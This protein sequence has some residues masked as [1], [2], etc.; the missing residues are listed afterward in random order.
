MER[1]K[2]RKTVL[3]VDDDEIIRTL[4]KLFLNGIPLTFWEENDGQGALHLARQIHPDLIITDLHMPKMDGA[5]LTTALRAEPDVRLANVPIIVITGTSSDNQ[6][7][8]YQAGA[9]VVLEK[10][11]ARKLLLTAMEQFLPK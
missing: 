2:N 7:R 5:Q 6:D 4:L 3:L 9:N 1:R 8:A 11:V 10:P